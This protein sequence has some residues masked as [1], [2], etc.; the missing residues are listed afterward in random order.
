MK[1]K[2]YLQLQIKRTTKIAPAI[3]MITLATVFCIAL[4]ASILLYNNSKSGDKTKLN[5][6]IV[7]DTTG[8]H[9][10][11]GITAL[12]NFDSSRYSIDFQ[13]MP[14]EEAIRKL[15]N[16]EIS[17]YIEIPDDFVEGIVTGDNHPA[18]YVVLE[19]ITGF[20]TALMSEIANVAS[21]WILLSQRAI[22]SMQRIMLD[23]DE[24][25]RNTL[26][27][28]TDELNLEYIK[29]ILGRKEIYDVT[30]TGIKDS[31]TM[32]GYYIC[33]IIIFFLLI[34]GIS[35][36]KLLLKKNYAMSKALYSRGIKNGWQLFCEYFCYLMFTISTLLVLAFIFGIVI[37]IK[38]FGIKEL[39]TAGVI[40]ALFFV[41]KIIPVIIMLTL[42]HTI[43]YEMVSG[44]VNAIVLQFIVAAVLAYISGCFYPN[45][46][47]PE[48]I[49]SFA[50]ILPSGVGFSYIRKSMTGM[51]VIS[52]LGLITI[53]SM[54]FA[55]IS[56]F[57]RKHRMEGDLH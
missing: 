35:C 31:I 27:E 22:Y 17:G 52:D 42:M 57:L 29:H 36:N 54:A 28:Y 53:Y 56:L 4:T 43:F 23:S 41:I 7:G 48:T 3:L 8:T 50:A 1:K 39:K 10:G 37:S 14:E 6:G 34:W 16:H 32:E 25:D 44:T 30:E 21:D 26:Y 12:E 46:F 15:N 47:F 38:D 13:E 51:S 11:I 49:Q 18:T 5:I 45:T 19:D 40:D 33:G 20:E 55:T 24:C 2:T 9:L